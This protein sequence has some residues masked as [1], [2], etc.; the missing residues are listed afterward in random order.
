MGIDAIVSPTQPPFDPAATPPS[1]GAAASQQRRAVFLDRDGVINR[2][3]VRDGKPYAPMALEE[4]SIYEDAPEAIA[5]LK[6]AGYLT[7]V[8]T[9]QPDVARGKVRGEVIE[10]LHARMHELLPLDDCLVCPHDDGEC[11]CRKP[12]PGMLLEASERHGIDLH[13]SVMVGDRWRDVDAGRNAGCQ[14]VFID[15]GY[16]EQLP[17]HPPHHVCSSL[18]EAVAWILSEHRA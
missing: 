13:R 1:T 7:I 18:G 10:S 4:F 14:T 2:V 12:L 3:F 9:N 5:R 6:Q 11:Q 16:S 15:R 17:E 8:V